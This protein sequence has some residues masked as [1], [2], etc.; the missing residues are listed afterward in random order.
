MALQTGGFAR[1]S[2]PIN[3]GLVDP[4]LLAVDYSRILQGAGQGLQLAGDYGNLRDRALARDQAMRTREAQIAATNAQAKLATGQAG[5]GLEL[6]PTETENRRNE[7]QLKGLE[8]GSDLERNP[9]AQELK[10]LQLDTGLG[11]QRFELAN[12]PREQNL[13][14]GAQNLQ[15]TQ[16]G[17]DRQKQQLDSITNETQRLVA[18]ETQAFMKAHPEATQQE[19]QAKLMT[20]KRLLNHMSVLDKFEKD[21]PDFI[22]SGAAAE[23]AKNKATQ[24]ESQY[25]VEHGGIR[26]SSVSSPTPEREFNN[27]GARNLADADKILNF[28]SLEAIRAF[29]KTPEGKRIVGNILSASPSIGY[30][31]QKENKGKD[32]L[33]VEAFRKT[34]EPPIP[35]ATAPSTQ[36]VPGVPAAPAPLAAPAPPPPAAPPNAAIQYLRQNPSLAAQFERKYGVSAAQYLKP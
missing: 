4:R 27:R 2:T 18:E 25:T 33:A 12:Q 14:V 28:G 22:A 36:P 21:N 1:T 29:Q 15:E 3:P 24:A 34:L 20:S 6:L 26:P 31:L 10:N 7:L 32:L 35:A 11:S 17:L 19:L 8:L 23:Y 16:Q 9:R 5:A 13:K 30:N